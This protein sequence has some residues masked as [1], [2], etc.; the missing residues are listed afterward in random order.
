MHMFQPDLSH[1]ANI[2]EVDSLIVVDENG[3]FS[4]MNKKQFWKRDLQSFMKFW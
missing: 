3:Q 1:D 4:I 2:Q